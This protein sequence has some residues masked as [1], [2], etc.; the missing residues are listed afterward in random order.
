MRLIAVVTLIYLPA[1]FVSAFF[2]TDVIRYQPEWDISSDSSTGR[3]GNGSTANVRGPLRDESYSSIALERW[4][5]VTG[6]LTALTFALAW[7]WYYYWEALLAG[8]KES[9]MRRI[10]NWRQSKAIVFA[11]EEKAVGTKKTRVRLKRHVDGSGC[12]ATKDMTVRT[13]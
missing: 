11:D 1:M 10:E 4:W 7:L 13:S 5:Q 12:I 6:P 9:M 2:S 8:L 3:P